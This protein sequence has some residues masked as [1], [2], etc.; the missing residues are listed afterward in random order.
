MKTKTVLKNPASNFFIGFDF[1]VIL[2]SGDFFETSLRLVSSFR[3]H[4]TDLLNR[5]NQPNMQSWSRLLESGRRISDLRQRNLIEL[6][7]FAFFGSENGTMAKFVFQ[8]CQYSFLKR[9][10]IRKLSK[11]FEP[12]AEQNC[13]IRFP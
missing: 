2:L 5:T 13:E 9:C 8:K 12:T 11:N 1:C 10:Q 6:K 4:S 3:N 7:L